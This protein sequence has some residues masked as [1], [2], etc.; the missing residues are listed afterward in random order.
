[1]EEERKTSLDLLI[2]LGRALGG[3]E[4]K[5]GLNHDCAALLGNMRD[6]RIEQRSISLLGS[7]SQASKPLL[8]CACSDE[9]AKLDPAWPAACKV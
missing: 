5:K 4:K 7:R 6:G 9:S 1:M 2:A 3:E 8:I